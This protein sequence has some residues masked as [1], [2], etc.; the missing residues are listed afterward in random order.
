MK[1]ILII[2]ASLIAGFVG[3]IL[4]TLVTHSTRQGPQE[5]VIRARSFEL[6]DE[7][8]KVISYWGIDKNQYAV[9]A[10]GSYWPKGRPGGGHGSGQPQ[11]D[12]AD[13]AN[14]R[15]AFGV[16]DDYPFLDLRALDGK[17]RMRLNLSIYEKPL[18]WMA[19]ESG[20]RLALGV[21]H[22]DTPRPGDNDWFLKFKP[23]RAWIG[24]GTRSEGGQTYVQGFLGVNP[25]KVKSPY[26]NP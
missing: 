13:P 8:G 17:P 1:Q 16:V 14:Q 9:L 5:P 2:G 7:S 19:D 25:D 15:A 12:L 11:L 6:M 24:M 21:E 23:D 3:G 4:G 18:L 10:F 22:S 20:K 26:G